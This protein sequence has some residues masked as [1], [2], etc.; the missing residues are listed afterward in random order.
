MNGPSIEFRRHV[1]EQIDAIDSED[2]LEGLLE[3]ILGRINSDISDGFA[4]QPPDEV[5]AIADAWLSIASYALDG[6]YSPASRRHDIAGWSKGAV[7]KLRKMADALRPLLDAIGRG[8]RSASY[9]IGVAFPLGASIS[10]TWQSTSQNSPTVSGADVVEQLFRVL[11]DHGIDDPEVDLFLATFKSDLDSARS[12]IDR[13]AN[14][15]A[16]DT[17]V[18]ERHRAI[19]AAEAPE[20]WLR[21]MRGR[22]TPS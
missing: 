2:G 6:F 13:G 1:A 5:L 15:N 22:Q 18:L 17:E 14:V 20:L 10:L 9:S 3:E 12:A 8:F 4:E 19:L 21:Y 16:R 7:D 11:K